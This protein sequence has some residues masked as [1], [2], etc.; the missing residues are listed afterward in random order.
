MKI[1][2]EPFSLPIVVIKEGDI[3]INALNDIGKTKGWLI[4]LYLFYSNIP[5]TSFN[6]K[7]ASGLTFKVTFFSPDPP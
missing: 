2:P 3:D 6:F 5:I 4:D 1:F 7:R